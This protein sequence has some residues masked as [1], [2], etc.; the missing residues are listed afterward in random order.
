MKLGQITLVGALCAAP[1]AAQA[2]LF[3]MWG[4]PGDRLGSSVGSIGDVNGDGHADFLVGAEQ[5]DGVQPDAGRVFVMSTKFGE[6]GLAA[7]TFLG[8]H[9][10]DRVGAAVAGIS[11]LTGDGIREYVVGAPGLDNGPQTDCGGFYVVNGATSAVLSSN[12]GGF[13]GMRLGSAVAAIGDW[14]GDGKSE[15]A[16]GA[17]YDSTVATGA[18]AVYLFNGATN[19]L[20]KTLYGQGVSDHFGASVAGAGRHNN[21]TTPDLIVGAPD[22]DSGAPLFCGRAYVYS[23]ASPYPLLYTYTGTY[24]VG[25]LGTSVSGGFD[26][27]ADGFDEVLIG[28]PFADVNGNFSGR[29]VVLRGGTFTVLY[30]IAGAAS[31]NLTGQAVLGLGDVNQDGKGDFVVGSPEADG[32]FDVDCGHADVYSGANGS[33][34]YHSEGSEPSQGYGWSLGAPGLINKDTA[35]DVIMGSPYDYWT[36]PYGGSL[37]IGLSNVPSP[38]EYCTG[39]LNSQGC[40]PRI[41]LNGC[42][43]VSV[44][45]NFHIQA[46]QCLVNKPGIMMWSLQAAALP[47][48]GGTLC[49]KAPIVRTPVQ[50]SQAYNTGVCDGWY[51][52]HMTNAYMSANGLVPGVTFYAQ[53][54]MRDNGFS[55]PNNIGLTN[56]MQTLVLL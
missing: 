55:A 53:Y 19:S 52:Y 11:D 54:W 18:G 45:E 8:L 49:V 17:P 24:S 2:G 37:H 51:D 1:A 33:V 30:D 32:A 44:A 13:S 7:S 14:T 27:N 28:E 47:F 9:T 50:Y 56:A 10:G 35:A 20:F 15:Y 4:A 3:G 41:W 22:Y 25:H 23:G 39:K 46:I 40:S 43:T 38:T 16:I 5:A 12:V 36:A 6:T 48:G 42:P 34:L 31:G 29:A 21:D 26:A